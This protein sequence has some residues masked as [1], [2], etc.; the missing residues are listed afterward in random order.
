MSQLIES[1]HDVMGDW[2][3]RQVRPGASAHSHC[4]I[5]YGRGRQ[6]SRVQAAVAAPTEAIA[7][8]AIITTARGNGG[9]SSAHGETAA[10]AVQGFKALSKTLLDGRTNGRRW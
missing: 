9:H 2:Q 5:A 10:G 7:Q 4:P 6:S 8:H 1:L 3:A